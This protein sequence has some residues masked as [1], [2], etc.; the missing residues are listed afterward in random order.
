MV[1]FSF[2]SIGSILALS[3]LQHPEITPVANQH[4]IRH[5]QE[6]TCPH[7]TRNRTDVALQLSRVSNRFDTAIEDVVAVVRD[8]QTAP[9]DEGHRLAA[10]LAEPQLTQGQGEGNH[11]D[12]QLP[13]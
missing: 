4:D 1:G 2:A 8:K 6:Q 5:P 12:G 10:Q 7:D 3:F 13:P 11:L 9:L